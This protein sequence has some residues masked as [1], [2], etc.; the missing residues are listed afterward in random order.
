[1]IISVL[2]ASIWLSADLTSGH[3]YTA[4]WIPL[5]NAFMRLIVFMF[6]AFL[7]SNARKDYEFEKKISRTD[8]LTG[9]SNT[10]SFMEQ[11]EIEKNR[12]LRFKQP[13]TL[14][15]LDVDHFKQ[16]NDIHGH[17]KGDALLQDLGKSIKENIRGYDVAARIGGDEF[18]I[19][20]PGTDAKQAQE[21]TAKIK[22]RIEELFQKYLD[23][24]SLSMGVVTII[25]TA[26]SIDELIKMADGLMYLVKKGSKNNI[27]YDVL[28]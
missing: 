22:I 23:A 9:L 8:L 26:H 24:L 3:D 12:A 2:S 15:Y 17:A 7:A 10:R 18:V 1:M 19:L 5:W 14:A 16:L 11:A 4:A 6:V 28:N 25:S 21:V 13:F 20:F 27:I